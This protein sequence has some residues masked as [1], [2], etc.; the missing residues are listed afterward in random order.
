MTTT[1]M[2]P[3]PRP[4]ARSPADFA[5]ATHALSL[6]VLVAAPLLIV[7]PP[8][9]L[10]FYT[11]SLVTV[12]VVGANHLTLERTG[13]GILDTLAHR[14]G[15]RDGLPSERARELRDTLRRHKEER[16]RPINL[17]KEGEEHMRRLGADGRAVAAG[18]DPLSSGPEPAE[19]HDDDA[20]ARGIA[21][22]A[23]KLWL[24]GEGEDWKEKRMREEREAL[25]AGK[26]YLDLITN[27][28]FEVWNWGKKDKDGYGYGN[29]V[30]DVE[31]EKKRVEDLKRAKGR[32]Q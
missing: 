1:P 22:M 17:R 11:F 13:L 8:R 2:T 25:A 32:K 7:L 24:G 9:K 21:G 18:P 31:A 23:K 27:Q 19:R 5:S 20:P 30:G 14:V 6:L 15:P 4:P 10:D 12:W 28:I 16:D 29:Y 26:S 3:D